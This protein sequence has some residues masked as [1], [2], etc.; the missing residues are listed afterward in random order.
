MVHHCR[1]TYRFGLAVGQKAG[2]RP[3]AEILYIAS[4]LHDLGLEPR[5]AEAE[6]NF[7]DVGGRA[8]ADFL[9]ERGASHKLADAVRAAIE[10]HTQIATAEDPVPERALLH[11]GAM[12]DVVGMRIDQ[13]PAETLREILERHPRAGCKELLLGA[14][15]KQ[16]ALKPASRIAAAF[17]T[18]KLPALI[19]AAPFDE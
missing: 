11:M 3:D 18:F 7:E 13:I 10:L 15:S 6:G 9:L 12:V 5:F 4:L 17:E 8:A 2:L 19:Q 14:L 1:R 16:V